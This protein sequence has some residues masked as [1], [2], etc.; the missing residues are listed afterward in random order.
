MKKAKKSKISREE[1]L[2]RASQNTGRVMALGDVLDNLYA[3][4]NL[5][6]AQRNAYINDAGK[7][8]ERARECDE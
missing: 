6:E 3:L 2:R 5:L 7:F 1:C 8:L 4:L